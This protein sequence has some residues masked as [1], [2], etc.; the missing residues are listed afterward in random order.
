MTTIN[1][2]TERM[3]ALGGEWSPTRR[4]ERVS[5]QHEICERTFDLEAETITW[6]PEERTDE[7]EAAYQASLREDAEAE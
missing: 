5:Y 1:D 4:T 7:L 6:T 3:T 2:M